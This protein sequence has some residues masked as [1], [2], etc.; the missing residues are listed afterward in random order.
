VTAKCEH[1]GVAAPRLERGEATSSLGCGDLA[2]GDADSLVPEA[3]P[4]SAAATGFALGALTAAVA[5]VAALLLGHARRLDD[6]ATVWRPLIV[7]CDN[8]SPPAVAVA[9]RQ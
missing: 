5:V 4:V 7:R 2:R 1:R 3:C 6:E 8:V 9:G